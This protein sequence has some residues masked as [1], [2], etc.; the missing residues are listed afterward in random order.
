MRINNRVDDFTFLSGMT[1]LTHLFLRNTGFNDLS[2]I[3]DLALQKLYLEEERVEHMELVYEMPSLEEL[4]LSRNLIA[5]IDT[6]LLREINPQI[7]MSVV[8][9]AEHI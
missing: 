5:S 6:K 4:V 1:S 8:S 3:Q 2:V 9:H 7:V